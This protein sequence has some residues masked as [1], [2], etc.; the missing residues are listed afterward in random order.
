MHIRCSCY[1]HYDNIYNYVVDNDVCDYGVDGDG[2]DDGDD[3]DD[4]GTNDAL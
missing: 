1:D 3:D 4:S 2:D